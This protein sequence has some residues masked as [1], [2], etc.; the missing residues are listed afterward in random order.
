MSTLPATTLRVSGAAMWISV[1]KLIF[2]FLDD[3]NQDNGAEFVQRPAST[4]FSNQM[5]G[6]VTAGDPWIKNEK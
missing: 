2:N 5:Y 6:G 4:H 1:S 3:N